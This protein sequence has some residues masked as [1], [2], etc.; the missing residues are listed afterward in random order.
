MV[1]LVAHFAS[2]QPKELPEQLRVPS[3]QPVPAGQATPAPKSEAL[4]SNDRPVLAFDDP[5]PATASFVAADYLFWW[6]HRGPS[7]ALLT[8][9]PNNGK[10]GDRLLGGILGEQGTMPLFTSDNLDYHTTSGMRLAAGLNLD[11]DRFWS[12]EGGGFYLPRRSINY[13]AA[14]N[15]DGTPLLTIP[16]LDAASGLQQALDVSSQDIFGSPFLTGSISIHSDIQIWGYELNILAHSIRTPERSVELFA[17]FRA[18]GLDENLT[19]AQN[20]T[21]L[22]DGAISLQFP[23]VGQ[24][25]PAAGIQGY[26]SVPTGGVVTV[27]DS[28]SA[29][30]RFYG[31]QVGARFLWDLGR[32]SVDLTAKAALGVT[33]QEVTISGFSSATVASLRTNAPLTNLTTP[34]GMFALQNNIGSFN[35]NQFTVAPEIGLNIGY[36]VTPW[37]TFRIGYSALYWS[38]VARPGAQIDSVLNSKLIPTGGFLPFQTTPT[39]GLP[40]T[41][42]AF[43]PGQEQGRPYFAFHDTA[44]W[45]HGVHVGVEFRY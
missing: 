41:P 32:F 13:R 4:T 28:F 24:G 36:A 40:T 18:L 8:T 21:A 45:A 17:G 1:L 2:A 15:P 42:G 5:R 22:Q 30:N 33:H 14:G 9:A 43:V 12:L 20:I 35:Q 37:M 19:I 38:N 39:G 29:R 7:P 44:F 27:F 34:G 23:S 10:V 11:S 25:Q 26:Y 16:F 6:L 3:Q 31:G